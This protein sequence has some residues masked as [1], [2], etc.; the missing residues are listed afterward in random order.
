[1]KS[2]T[3]YEVILVD[4]TETPVERP[5]KSKNAIIQGKR[6]NTL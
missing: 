1:M 6:K 5:K 4:A 2:D 3:E